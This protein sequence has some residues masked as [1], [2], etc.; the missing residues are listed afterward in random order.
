MRIFYS[1]FALI[2]FLSSTYLAQE[3][4]G[5]VFNDINNNQIF[6]KDE[7][8]IEDILISNGHD[9]VKTDDAGFYKIPVTDGDIVFVVKPADYNT[10][11]DENNIPR[12]YYIYKPTGSPAL[13]FGGIK[14]TGAIP[15]N[16]NFPLYKTTVN[17]NL[18]I[19]AFGDPQPGNN[20]DLD[21]MRD[22]I[23]AELVGTDADFVIALGDI[24]SDNLSLYPRYI[25][26][27]QRL[28]T[29][30]YNVPG[31][32]DQD[33]DAIDDNGALDT[34]KETFGPANYS[35]NVGDLHIVVLD[36][37]QFFGVEK[38]S[39]YVES[40]NDEQLEWL[41]KDLSYVEK[42]KR[43]I[44]TMHGP[45]WHSRAKEFSVQKTQ[46]FLDILS[47]KENLLV[48]SGHY[49][50]N[51]NLWLTSEHGW[52]GS[53]PLHNMICG[54]ICGSWWSGPIDDRGIPV[55]DQRDGVPNGYM[56]FN[57]TGIDY[58]YKYKAARFDDSYQ[59]KISLPKGKVPVDS[60]LGMKI[61]VNVFQADKNWKI[62]G[63]L[64]DKPFQLT[65]TLAKDPQAVE[66]YDNDPD[67]W[68][69]W[70]KPIETGHM[71]ISEIDYTL[72]KGVHT[73]TITAV[74]PFGEKYVENRVIEVE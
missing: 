6:D 8:G 38:K 18:K 15:E 28:G 44:L 67:L 73:I 63:S 60:T 41:K 12:F 66:L 50:T 31:N 42:D 54:A 46:E 52:N 4:K 64:D 36:N 68:N 56:T 47:D 19:L 35:F 27:M 72:S 20:E 2:L 43:I 51:D 58:T 70:I 9:F 13:K 65:Q 62:E 53:K 23:I 3:I 49:H 17:E 37:I 10:F 29:T 55:S 26:I 21:Y 48:L 25:D 45:I 22:D 33:Y 61:F 57:F 30:I 11:V 59:M 39:K 24:V 7:K 34:F 14:P 16:V 69:S 32:H 40:F 71:Y 74:D 1:I 5:F